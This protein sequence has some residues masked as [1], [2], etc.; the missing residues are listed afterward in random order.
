MLHE[1]M[2]L[3]MSLCRFVHSPRYKQ[4]EPIVSNGKELGEMKTVTVDFSFSGKAWPHTL[5]C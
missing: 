2:R 1:A 4:I 3:S 5:R